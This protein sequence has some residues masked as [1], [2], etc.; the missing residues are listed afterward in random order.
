MEV[1]AEFL[2]VMDLWVLLPKGVSYLYCLFIFVYI[3][4]SRNAGCCDW[5][6]T[7]HSVVSFWTE[8]RPSVRNMN[9]RLGVTA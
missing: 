8:R 2:S 4:L 3:F 7:L 6:K 1:R 9:L 5:G